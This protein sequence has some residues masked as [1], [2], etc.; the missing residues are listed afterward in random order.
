[1]TQ[2]IMVIE[3]DPFIRQALCYSLRQDAY[4]ATEFA[5]G[6]TALS[7]ILEHRPDLVIL[8]I[9]LPDMN[10]FTFLRHLRQE[11]GISTP[12]IVLSA[13]ESESDRVAAL[14]LGADDY[15]VKPYS[16]RELI[17]RI[18]TVL[19]RSQGPKTPVHKLNSQ[20]NSPFRVYED[21]K[22]IFYHGVKL[23]LPRFEFRLLLVFIKHEGIVLSRDRLLDLAWYDR[24]DP[25]ERSVDT[26]VGRLRIKLKA[27]N[28]EY[29]PIVTYPYEGYAL[30]LESSSCPK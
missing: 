13:R 29:D 3:D 4:E 15:V 8:D 12:V 28:P 24:N 27:I 26:I 23:E 2:N 14:E 1:M 6:H 10:G 21:K 5:V 18:R 25:Y 30:V 20:T 11:H 7:S 9:G 16:C 19:R 22:Q 17:A